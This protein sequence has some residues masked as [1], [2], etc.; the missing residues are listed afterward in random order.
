MQNLLFFLG[1]G[2]LSA[3]CA[4]AML[5]ALA[6]PGNSQTPLPDALLS[7]WKMSDFD[8]HLVPNKVPNAGALYVTPASSEP[9]PMLVEEN[10]VKLLR[11]LDGQSL[12]GEIKDIPSLGGL[13]EGSPFSL[14]V[15][16]TPEDRPPG[17]MGGLFEAMYFERSGFR[18]VLTHD[19]RVAVEIF[20]GDAEGDHTG[21]ESPTHLDLES[22]HTAEV[23][24]DGKQVTLLLDGVE[25]SVKDMALPAPFD[26]PFRVGIASG[27]DYHFIG[28]IDEIK[29]SAIKAQP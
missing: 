4:G 15:T 8:G 20:L 12:T 13:G 11:F 22:Q 23:R 6:G 28:L 21:I 14:K 1:T 29:I 9:P 2:N 18:L 27:T 19:L 7:E 17:A 16:F 10:G 3:L 24:F 25:E 26:G 5:M